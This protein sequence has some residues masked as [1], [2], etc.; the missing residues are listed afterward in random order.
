MTDGTAFTMTVS[1]ILSN[2]WL[3]IKGCILQYGQ[4]VCYPVMDGS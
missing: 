1:A 2:D 3:T 4:F